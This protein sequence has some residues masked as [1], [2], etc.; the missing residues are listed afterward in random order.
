MRAAS[1]LESRP[2]DRKR[3]SGTSL[4]RW[5]GRSPPGGSEG[6]RPARASPAERLVRARSGETS[7]GGARGP[8]ARDQVRVWPG[9]SFRMPWKKVSVA[10]QVAGGEELRER[11][12][13]ER[14]AP[15][16]HRQD[17]LDLGGEQQLPV[18]HR[19][20]QR[21]DAEPVAR[22]EQALAASGPRGR[23]R[24]CPGAARRSARPPPRRGAGSSR[25]RSGSGSGGRAPRGPGAARRGCRSRRCR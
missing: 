23:R 19:V 3:P 6:R 4:M 24:T 18:G 14:R 17:R 7:S 12:A 22:E 13:V 9:G 8:P 20:V 25:C 10:G 2:P 11:R 21:L 16:R 1:P 5:L 15:G